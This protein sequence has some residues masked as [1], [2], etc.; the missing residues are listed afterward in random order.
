MKWLCKS[1]GAPNGLLLLRKEEEGVM[2]PK[3]ILSGILL[4][5]CQYLWG[6]ALWETGFLKSRPGPSIDCAGVSVHP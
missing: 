6:I 4:L 5:K 2:T 1:A 3:R